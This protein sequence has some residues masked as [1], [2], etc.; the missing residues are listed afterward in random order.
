MKYSIIDGLLITP[1]PHGK[2]RGEWLIK[3][4]STACK[5]CR[6]FRGINS[7]SVGVLIAPQKILSRTNQR[8]TPQA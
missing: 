4:A 1:C 5:Q 2:K 6:W 7:H 3:V 8:I